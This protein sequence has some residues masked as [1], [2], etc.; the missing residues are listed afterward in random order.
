MKI[1]IVKET[2]I[3]KGSNSPL[4]NLCEV[5][6][7][8]LSKKRATKYF[9]KLK[10]EWDSNGFFFFFANGNS[11]KGALY[12]NEYTGVNVNLSID[13]YKCNFFG[14]KGKEVYE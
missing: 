10:K 2:C 14:R 11:S 8:T 3:T 6:L 4:H 9:E 13:V 12:T 5:K 7:I 1:Y